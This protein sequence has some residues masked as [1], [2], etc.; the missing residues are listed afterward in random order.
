VDIRKEKNNKQLSKVHIIIIMGVILALIIY[1]FN[2]G[3]KKNIDIRET[4]VNKVEQ[5][6]LNIQV[7]GY[8]KLRSSKQ[9]LLTSQSNATVDE[10]VLKPGAV[11][12]IDSIIL[13][14]RSPALDH[15]VNVTKQEYTRQ[16]AILRKLKLIQVREVLANE[17][18]FELIKADYETVAMREVAMQDLVVKGIVSKLDFSEVKLKVAQLKKRVAIIEK[19]AEKLKLVHDESIN[20]QNEAI[21]NAKSNYNTVLQLYEQ[22][23]VRAGMNGI[24]QKLPVELGQSLAVGEQV[25]LIG[26]TEDL[27]ALVKVPQADA[28]Q[29]RVGQNASIDT[30]KNIIEAKVIRV[31]PT[32]EDGSVEIEIALTGTLPAQ[33][34]P[35]QNIDAIINIEKINAAYFIQ[36][37]TNVVAFSTSTLYKLSEDQLTAYA[38]PVE[39]GV[40]SGRFIQIISGA[41][42]GESLIVSDLSYLNN[43]PEVALIQ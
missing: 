19:M 4:L 21:G 29:V 16:Q 30:R 17:E 24:L 14:L 40:T 36:R 28:A 41:S 18:K 39:F 26:G 43:I 12:G 42:S 33:L 15:E 25:A 2:S 32:V 31:S 3:Y 6:T 37:P 38:T 8:G 35:E 11:V 27:V 20:I 1:I 34:R 10:I 5:G 9:K 23:T 7:E 22:L 13:Q